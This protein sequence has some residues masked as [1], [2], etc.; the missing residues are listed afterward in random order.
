VRPERLA[1]FVYVGLAIGAASIGLACNGESS[2]G[3]TPSPQPQ[4]SA[5]SPRGT[6]GPTATASQPTV[7]V[8]LTPTVTAGPQATLVAGQLPDGFPDDFPLFPGAEVDR[9]GV[10][11]ARYVVVFTSSA[12]R[13]E[14]SAFYE[15]ALSKDGWRI[16]TVT[17]GSVVEERNLQVFSVTGPSFMGS[18]AVTLI[19]NSGAE[20]GTD[21]VVVLPID[22]G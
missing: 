19:G 1:I 20:G 5:T 18:G 12:P 15:K 3:S 4:A 8:D 14:L 22:G 16:I 7:V 9:G 6:P 10:Q 17:E 11:D 13:K 21:I 2:P